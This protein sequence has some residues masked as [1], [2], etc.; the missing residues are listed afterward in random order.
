MQNKRIRDWSVAVLCARKHQRTSARLIQRFHLVTSQSTDTREQTSLWSDACS[1]CLFVSTRP[2]QIQLE[3]VMIM[4]LSRE[5][6]SKEKRSKSIIIGIS[7]FAQTSEWLVEFLGTIKAPYAAISN[8]TN[9]FRR[10]KKHIGQWRAGSH[11]ELLKGLRYFLSNA[12]CFL[13]WLVCLC[14]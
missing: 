13:S 9:V 8:W 14:I 6:I 1:L 2:E 7:V 4:W 5:F 3:P 10:G 11:L 12:A